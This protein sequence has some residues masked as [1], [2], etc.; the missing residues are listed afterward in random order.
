MIRTGIY[1]GGK[2]YYREP[3]VHALT[4]GNW[5]KG[6]SGT[7]SFGGDVVTYDVENRLDIWPDGNQEVSFELR[8]GKAIVKTLGK[9]YNPEE[10]DRLIQPSKL[11]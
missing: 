4:G 3:I 9:I 11:I 5:N 2:V 7:K 10:A 1:R 8:E 6:W